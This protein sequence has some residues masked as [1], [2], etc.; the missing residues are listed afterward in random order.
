MELALRDIKK[1]DL[2]PLQ[3]VQSTA[4]ERDLATKAKYTSLLPRTSEGG[5]DKFKVRLGTSL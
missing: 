1:E 3:V 5:G 2:Q 4:K